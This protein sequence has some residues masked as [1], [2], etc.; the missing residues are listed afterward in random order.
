MTTSKRPG[1]YGFHIDGLSS[2]AGFLNAVP[3]SWPTISVAQLPELD[4]PADP[5][6]EPDRAVHDLMGGGQLVLDRLTRHATIHRASPLSEDALIHPF[7]APIAATM[8]MWEGWL[9][10]HAGGFVRGP[11]SWMVVGEREA[12]K[13]STM[14]A[15]AARNLPVIADDLTVVAVDRVFAGPR[16][17]DLRRDVADRID[18]ARWITDAGQRERWRI[19]LGDVDPE[20]PPLGGVFQLAWGDAVKVERLDAAGAMAT[21]L[22]SLTVS[23]TINMPSLMSVGLLPFFRLTRPRT[24]QATDEAI[25]AILE[26]AD[27]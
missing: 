13:S 3:D 26:T 9:P 16:T 25:D 11:A 12:G 20:L 6:I 5:S 10:F 23:R 19:N 4:P 7:L 2:T 17:L 1:A 22:E 27:S 21:L 14:S 18:G 24:W 8:A 15:L